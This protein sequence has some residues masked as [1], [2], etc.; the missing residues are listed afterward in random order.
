MSD[1]EHTN[2][3]T[4]LE[5]WSRAQLIKN[6]VTQKSGFETVS[7]DTD[8]LARFGDIPSSDLREYLTTCL[9][10]ESYAASEVTVADFNGLMEENLGDAAP[11]GDIF[12]F[13]FLSIATSVGGN[14]VCVDT[15][16]AEVFW[17][18][19]TYF[20]DDLISYEDRSTG[21]Y[22]HLR[23]AYTEETVRRALVLL[24]EDLGSFVESLLRDE[25]TAALDE[26][27]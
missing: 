13:G 1:H 9:A 3:G 14:A 27:D 25:L 19:H 26:L 10:I 7:L 8:S 15:R 11:G 24:S 23:G 21:E 2:M 5:H 22:V 17:A 18:D 4:R 20:L 6:L 12:R 16:T